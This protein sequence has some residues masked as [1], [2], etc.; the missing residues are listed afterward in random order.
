MSWSYLLTIFFSNL[1]T[2]KGIMRSTITTVVLFLAGALVYSSSY[3]IVVFAVPPDPNWSASGTCGGPTTN[4]YGVTYQTCCWE[5]RVPG[6]LPPLNKVRYCQTCYTEPNSVKQ[7]GCFP[8]EKQQSSPTPSSPLAEPLQPGGVFEQSPPPII[9]SPKTDGVLEQQ[10]PDQGT[11]QTNDDNQ[12]LVKNKAKRS[13]DGGGTLE[14]QP[15]THEELP[16]KKRGNND[17]S[18]TPPACPDKGPIPPD[19]TLKPKF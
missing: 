18:P 6:K 13:E 4:Q 12:P 3:T 1:L 19:C 14:Q 5:E 17:N 7:A 15:Q 2:R 11:T 9:S 8:K 16:L 10:Q